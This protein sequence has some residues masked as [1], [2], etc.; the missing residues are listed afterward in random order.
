[1]G[2][3]DNVSEDVRNVEA[4]VEPRRSMFGSVQLCHIFSVLVL[5][6]ADCDDKAV[7]DLDLGAA[8]N[9]FAAACE[10]HADRADVCEAVDA[11]F[12]CCLKDAGFAAVAVV[13]KASYWASVC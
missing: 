4:P 3:R 5:L 11:V 13:G 8:V 7:S 6:D 9:E 10:T 12:R 2:I 1:M